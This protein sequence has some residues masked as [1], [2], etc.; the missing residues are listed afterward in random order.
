MNA[1]SADTNSMW[2]DPGDAPELTDAWFESATLMQ[3]AKV[4]RPGRVLGSGVKASQTVRFDVAIL[5][6]FKATGKGWQ[7]RM[8]DALRQWLAEHPLNQP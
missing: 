4:V 1:K 2:V 6:A 7:T 3:G 8:N 5:D